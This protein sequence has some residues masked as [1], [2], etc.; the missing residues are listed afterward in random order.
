MTSPEEEYYT[1]LSR[2]AGKIITRTESW[3]VC[4]FVRV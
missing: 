3:L 1:D 2:N 4:W